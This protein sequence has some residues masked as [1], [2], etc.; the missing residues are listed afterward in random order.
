VASLRYVAS[1]VQV[2]FDSFAEI[3]AQ[4]GISAAIARL[5]D[6]RRLI[7]LLDDF[8]DESSVLPSVWFQYM[9]AVPT[10]IAAGRFIRHVN[11]SNA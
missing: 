11:G 9:L 1:G 2:L 8:P 10:G 7:R 3:A 5:I 4:L 6:T